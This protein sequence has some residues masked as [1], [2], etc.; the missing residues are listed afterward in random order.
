MD[1]EE[2]P[3]GRLEERDPRKR[4]RRSSEMGYDGD[5]QEERSRYVLEVLEVV[6]VVRCRH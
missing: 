3:R 2:Y 5:R 1:T 4:K 6:E